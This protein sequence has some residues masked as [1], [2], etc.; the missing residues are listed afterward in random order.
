MLGLLADHTD[1]RTTRRYLHSS[2]EEID[3]AGEKV[4][5]ILN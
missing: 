4:V 2:L 5:Q 3:A 1:P